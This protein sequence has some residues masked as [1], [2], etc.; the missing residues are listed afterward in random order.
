MLL[1]RL[2]KLLKIDDV[3]YWLVMKKQEILH[4]VYFFSSLLLNKL[5]PYQS[6]IQATQNN[7]LENKIN[8]KN[9]CPRRTFILVHDNLKLYSL[10]REMCKTH[11]FDLIIILSNKSPYKEYKDVCTQLFRTVGRVLL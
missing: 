9:S 11:V 2:R 1:I 6:I 4:K 8:K 7:I 10:L 5:L 3:Q